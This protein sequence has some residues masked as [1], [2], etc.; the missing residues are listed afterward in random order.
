MASLPEQRPCLDFCIFIQRH[1]IIQRVL[2]L[3]AIKRTAFSCCS[4]CRE[5]FHLS[6]PLFTGQITPAEEKNNLS[7]PGKVLLSL[8]TR[9]FSLIFKN[10]FD[11]DVQAL[12]GDVT[13]LHGVA[14]PLAVALPAIAIATTASAVTTIAAEAA[15]PGVV[16][17]ELEEEEV[18]HALEADRPESRQAEE[19]LGEPA[20]LVLVVG[21]AVLL[22]GGVD[23]LAVALDLEGG[24][25]LEALRVRVE[26][27]DGA[28]AAQL[29]L[30]LNGGGENNVAEEKSVIKYSSKYTG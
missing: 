23:L 2:H 15:E 28:Q 13:R 14:V 8:P 4:F 20:R 12:R 5:G 26:E 27:D 30:V 16:L 6:T 1:D 22:E 21:A 7:H 9:V 3:F 11:E 18:L 19:E 17:D 10:V 24:L 29:G 25:L